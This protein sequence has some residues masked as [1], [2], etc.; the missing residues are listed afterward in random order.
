MKGGEDA[1]AARVVQMTRL[2]QNYFEGF[3]I[4]VPNFLYPIGSK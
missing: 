3:Q 2:W 1:A 4:S